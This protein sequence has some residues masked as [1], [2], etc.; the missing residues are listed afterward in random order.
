[1]TLENSSIAAVDIASIRFIGG[2][3]AEFSEDPTNPWPR[4]GIRVLGG[5]QLQLSVML[6]PRGLPGARRTIMQIV[7]TTSDTARVQ[8]RG[9]AGTQQLVITPTSLFDNVLVSVGSTARRFVVISNT[10]T[11]PVR[12]QMPVVSGPD[13]VNYRLGPLP[14]LDLEP[15]ATEYLEVTFA[16][17]VPGQSTAEIRFASNAGPEQVVTLGGEALRVR[18]RE[19][20]PNTSI[21]VTGGDET[22]LRASTPINA[23]TGSSA[24]TALRKR[25]LEAALTLEAAMPNPALDATT[26]AYRTGAESDVTAA[27][28]DD[29]GRLV[30]TLHAGVMPAGEHTLGIRCDV[31]AAGAYFVRIESAGAVRV[32]RFIVA[33]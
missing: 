20:D 6:Q 9:E 8:I 21:A 17:T 33:R 26:I 7:T 11:L 12:L 3:A 13:S 25:A 23:V 29:A 2:D 16:P 30:R 28:F 4:G 32:V 14:R 27:L 1:V 18:G 15:G 31:L 24:S 22:T 19:V 10:G 5:G